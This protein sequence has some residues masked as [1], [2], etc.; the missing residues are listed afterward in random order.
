MHPT[1]IYPQLPHF[2]NHGLTIPF[3]FIWK[4]N[5]RVFFS[6][7]IIQIP[8][9]SKRCSIEKIEREKSIKKREKKKEKEKLQESLQIKE[10]KEKKAPRVSSNKKGKSIF[11]EEKNIA[12]SKSFLY[13]PIFFPSIIPLQN[14]FQNH[15]RKV[16]S[17]FG[18]SFNLGIYI[19]WVVSFVFTQELHIFSL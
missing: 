12:T 4:K 9:S 8:K 17:S 19:T 18:Q 14:P 6:S 11:W 15:L 7:F 10:E 2:Q 16:R 1:L 5:L 3:H 13:E